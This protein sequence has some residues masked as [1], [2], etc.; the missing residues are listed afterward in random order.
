MDVILTI[1]NGFSDTFLDFTTSWADPHNHTFVLV[2]APW[3]AESIQLPCT[4]FNLVLVVAVC[5]IKHRK[6]VTTAQV[7]IVVE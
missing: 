7:G 4:S 5:H 6:M 3:R 1:L 2:D